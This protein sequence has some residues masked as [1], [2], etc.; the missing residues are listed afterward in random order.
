MIK[1]KNLGQYLLDLRVTGTV[2]VTGLSK[3]VQMAPIPGWIVNIFATLSITA[4]GTYNTSLSLYKNGV[5]VYSVTTSSIYFQGTNGAAAYGSLSTDPIA[6]AAGDIFALN[7]DGIGNAPVGAMVLLLIDRQ[8]P[9][10]SSNLAD[11][12]SKY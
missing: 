2:N 1:I 5:S 11:P 10:G 12:S 4:N 9:G 3:S 6:V 8:N 7:V